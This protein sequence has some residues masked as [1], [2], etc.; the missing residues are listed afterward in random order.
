MS[1]VHFI[2]VHVLRQVFSGYYIW[3]FTVNNV[4]QN[5]WLRIQIT[6]YENV[7]PDV[8][9]RIT[10]CMDTASISGS[11]R[12]LIWC[13]SPATRLT[14]QTA[15]RWH[16]LAQISPTKFSA[17]SMQLCYLYSTQAVHRNMPV[18]HTYSFHT[19]LH[20]RSAS[21]IPLCQAPA[22]FTLHLI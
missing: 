15:A 4:A 18:S 9:Y 1:L 17:A 10:G 6:G 7:K 21:H 20:S 11:I 8:G 16:Q 14:A 2:T 13:H 22:E 5:V 3:N 12:T 19:P